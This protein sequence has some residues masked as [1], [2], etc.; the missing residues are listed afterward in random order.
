MT[1]RT[2]K[3]CKHWDCGWCYAPPDSHSNDE[4]GQ[5][6]SPSECEEL[7]LQQVEDDED[8]DLY[9]H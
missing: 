3:C 9:L 5:C 1:N 8:E 7:R 4:G 2:S 6:N